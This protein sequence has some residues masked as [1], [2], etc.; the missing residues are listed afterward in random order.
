MDSEIKLFEQVRKGDKN[1]FE[2]LFR[3]YFSHLCAY[4]NSFVQDIDEAQDIVQD[5]LFD[6]WQKKEKLPVDVPVRAYLF[7][8]VHNRCLN[9]LKHKKVVQ[10][11][12]DTTLSEYNEE[13][14]DESIAEPNPLHDKIRQTIDKM[15]PERRK[16]F[17]MHRYDE[18]KYKEIAERLNISIKTVENQI[19]KA[20]NFLRDELKAFLPVVLFIFTE[21][22][23]KFFVFNTL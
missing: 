11:H 16:V 3:T 8:S 1:A 2:K 20:L 14:F 5:F 13:M 12:I 19:G 4:S 10:K 22:K 15:P 6:I 18:L 17:I 23:R 21:I 9:V 7:K